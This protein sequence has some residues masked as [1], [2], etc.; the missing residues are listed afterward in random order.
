MAAVAVAFTQE[1]PMTHEQAI[2][3]LCAHAKTSLWQLIDQID[4]GP[5]GLEVELLSR[6]NQFNE[7]LDIVEGRHDG[8]S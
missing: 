8:K 6:I 3:I 1:V 2:Q 4:H 7:A 5:E